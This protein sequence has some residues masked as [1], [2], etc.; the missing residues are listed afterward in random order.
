[1]WVP[2]TVRINTVLALMTGLLIG[3]VGFGALQAQPKA[4]A[5]YW[6]TE[7]LEMID[8]AAFMQAIAAVPATMRP[9]GGRYI[10]LGKIAAD[11][12]PP[13]RRITIIA[14]DSLDKAQQWLNDP[15]SV[16]ARAEAKKHAK[17]RSYTVEG[18]AN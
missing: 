17:T 8:Q 3:G 12:G 9:F 14:F 4:P 7:T 13:P 5:A 10:V 16:A 6:V 18:Q 11:E 1:M 2:M 15:A